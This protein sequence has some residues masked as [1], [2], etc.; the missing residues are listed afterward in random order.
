MLEEINTRPSVWYQTKVRNHWDMMPE[1]GNAPKHGKGGH[2]KSGHDKSGH[3]DHK[4]GDAKHGAGH[5]KK[6]G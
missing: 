3:G 1:G 6:E 4:G 5:G 2:G